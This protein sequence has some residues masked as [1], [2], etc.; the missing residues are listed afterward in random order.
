MILAA[1]KTDIALRDGHKASGEMKGRGLVE[2]IL[3]R[4]Y[5]AAM[6]ATAW[7]HMNRNYF[8]IAY[9]SSL[10]AAY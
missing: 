8:S 10:G 5:R 2:K 1:Q 3:F 9:F 4:S 7:R 6:Q